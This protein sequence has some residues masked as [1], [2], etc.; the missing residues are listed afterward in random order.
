MNFFEIEPNLNPIWIST[1]WKRK[2]KRLYWKRKRVNFKVLEAEKLLLSSLDDPQCGH[3]DKD[4]LRYL[5]RLASEQ[6]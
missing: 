1:K 5:S 4:G 2:R 3:M 6:S